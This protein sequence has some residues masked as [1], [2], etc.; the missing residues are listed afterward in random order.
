MQIFLSCNAFS[1]REGGAVSLDFREFNE[2]GGGGGVVEASAVHSGPW[3]LEVPWSFLP[4]LQ[5]I[6]GG[7][8][9][10]RVEGR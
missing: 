10:C 9:N 4:L 6:G 5:L 8:A 7:A 3:P 2:W 1:G